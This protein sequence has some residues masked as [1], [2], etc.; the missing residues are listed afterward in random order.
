MGMRMRVAVAVAVEVRMGIGMRED[1]QRIGQP[2]WRAA[3]R[4]RASGDTA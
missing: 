2:A 3:A 4:R 1:S